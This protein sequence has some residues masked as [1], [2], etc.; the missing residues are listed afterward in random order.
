MNQI[1]D[2]MFIPLLLRFMK[3]TDKLCKAVIQEGKN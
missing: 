3:E 1:A 2:L